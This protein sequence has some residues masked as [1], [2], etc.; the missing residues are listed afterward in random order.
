MADQEKQKTGPAADP[1]A[2]TPNV[3]PVI[4][5]RANFK[6][7]LLS[8]P[9]HF[10]T[11]PNLGGKVVLP[12]KFDTAF[13]E[14]TCLG[15]NPQ[16]NKLEAV[17]QIKQHNGYSTNACGTGSR[18][19]VRFFVQHG[20]VWHDLG[21]TSFDAFDIP[22]PL[23]LSYAVSI[24]FNEAH[25]FCTRENI[26]NVRAILSWSIEPTAGNP[27]FQPPW[28]NVLDTRVQVAP[29]LL[30]KVPIGTLVSEG[31]VKVDPTALAEIDLE[32]VLP[33][34][35]QPPQ[36]FSALKELY[37]KTD[38]PSHRFGFVEAQK[39]L[40]QPVIN[41]LPSAP[42][43][44]KPSSTTPAITDLFAGA[45]LAGILQALANQSGD[46]GFEEMMC[47]GYNPQTRELEA[48]I[49]IKRNAGYS[50]GLCTP[51]STEY[52]SFFAF[53]GGAWQS[54]GT[55]SVSVH[56]L[57]AIKPGHAV[58]YAVRRI[59]NMT[60]MPC[61]KLQGV[62][63]RAILSWQQQPTGP[64]FHPVWGNVI[65][66]HVQPIIGEVLPGEHMRL[67]RIGGVTIDRISDIT[68]LAY[69]RAIADP[70]HNLPVIAGDCDGYDSPFGGELIIE[71]DF[72]PKPDV[73]N[74]VTGAVLPGAK[75]IIYQVWG[76]RTD[77]ASTPFPIANSFWIAMFPPSAPFP[78]VSFLQHRVPPSGP[79]LGGVAGAEYYQYMESD[80]QAVNPRTL[81]AFEAG[82]LTEGDY[83]IE[84]RA[85]SW[86]GAT[87]VPMASKFKTI[88][89]FNG[90]EHTEVVSVG[91][92]LVTATMFRPQVALNLTS[93]V[94]CADLTVG[95]TL[96]GSYS[97]VDRF[98]S[99]ARISLVP[100][101]IG[102][103]PAPEN[104]VTIIPAAG[105]AA[106]YDGFNTT[107]SHGT[108]TLDTTGMEPCGYT[109][110]LVA[111]DRAIVDSHCYA[112]WNRIG[113]GF[114]LR[115]P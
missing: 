9:N 105:A 93:I 95:A 32:Q 10:G 90:Y 101:T 46:V 47:A 12:K 80:L 68:H 55:A 38:V 25:K 85:W 37:A 16:Q 77:I 39:L 58:M 92:P 67:M 22:G 14:V 88:H 104:A 45:E 57:A 79:V 81:A 24:D 96:T 42:H 110:E 50:G 62:P 7:L 99:S 34:K 5:E 66:T 36:P 35:P 43:A 98:F 106:S 26:L 8:N 60:E 17:V 113:V 76:T 21:D 15:L 48:V 2:D 73:F 115:R 91:P 71:G 72:T 65:N 40:E 70:A 11:F 56:D 52:V 59:S 4:P 20:A 49:Q 100:I 87:Y 83:L 97:V 82:G 94:D 33:S 53:F 23:P 69:P 114:C 19:Y 74:H 75:P 86:N 84:V 64:N 31:L 28:G 109:I 111:S 108:F 29:F 18:E 13:E 30:S 107:G 1:K 103:N 78:P 112:H 3:P 27:N 54:L 89:I 102:G 6:T 61:E 63:L 44:V 51:G 41:A